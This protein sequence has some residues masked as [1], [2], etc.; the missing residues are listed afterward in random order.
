M[1]LVKEANPDVVVGRMIEGSL[2]SQVSIRGGNVIVAYS[3]SVKLRGFELGYS[4]KRATEL[5]EMLL[6]AV[7]VAEGR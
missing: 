7:R 2:Q 4:P 3:N 1:S 6:E 5:A